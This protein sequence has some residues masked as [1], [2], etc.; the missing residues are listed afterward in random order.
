MGPQ[1]KKEDRYL[2]SG[3]HPE[4]E[5][6]QWVILQGSYIPFTQMKLYKLYY[7]L[8]CLWKL[9]LGTYINSIKIIGNNS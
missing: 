5:V 4:L 6:S 1:A 3:C 2:C 9:I 8:F 7:F